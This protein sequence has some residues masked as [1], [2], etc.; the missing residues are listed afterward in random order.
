[1]SLKVENLDFYFGKRQILKD[2]SFEAHKG[3]F[4]SILGP[5]GVG[6]STLF[7]CILNL[8]KPSS[9]S[10]SID[11][12]DTAQMTAAQRA[13]CIAYIPQ[14]HNPTFNFSVMDMVLMGTASQ[15]NTLAAAP[16]KA[17]IEIAENAMQRLNISHLAQRPYDFCSG[18]EKQLCLLARAIAQQAKILVMDEPSASLDFGNRI[19]V[20]QTVRGLAADGYAVVQTTH[21]PEQAFMYSD[22]ILAIH[23]GQVLALGTPKEVMTGSLMSK[24]YG[25]PVEVHSLHDD[26]IRVCVPA[27]RM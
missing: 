4:L 23:E 3:E 19:R 13:R 9:G 18:G 21:D 14:Y 20:M 16:G 8:L 25:I 17:Q 27:N 11:G 6:K 12:K 5:N 15:M 22:K 1:M 24:L 2:I 10:I 7:R 26:G